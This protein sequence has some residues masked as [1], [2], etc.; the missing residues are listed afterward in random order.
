MIV[1]FDG[2][3]EFLSN[4][5]HSPIFYEG[6][7]Y[8]TNEHFFQAMKTLDPEERKEIA[9]A[10]TPGQAK[11]MGRSVTL[12]PDWERI[13][14]DVMRTGLMLKFTDAALAKKLLDTGDEELVE[15]NWW[16]DNTWGNCHCPKCSRLGGRNLLGMLLME[17]R[18]ELQYGNTITEMA[19]F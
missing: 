7:V 2:E 19:H 13:K 10:D 12:R 17:V 6:I 18:K 11:R 4:F 1:E 16:H 5:Y 3:N 15:G 14:V 8:P 9:A